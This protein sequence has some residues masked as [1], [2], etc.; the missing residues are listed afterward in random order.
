M[1]STIS[2]QGGPTFEIFTAQGRNP[3]ANWKVVPQTAAKKVFDQTLKANVF[4]LEGGPTAL[5]QA[6]KE[7]KKSCNRKVAVPL[8]ACSADHS[9]ILGISNYDT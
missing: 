2:F 7:E 9:T 4:V 1:A 8:T 3:L 6:P 5:M